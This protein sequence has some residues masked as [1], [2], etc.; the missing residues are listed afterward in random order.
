[1]HFIHKNISSP[2]PKSDKMRY[3]VNIINAFLIGIS[4]TKLDENILSSELEVNSYDLVRHD[5]S[6][7]VGDITCYITDLQQHRKYFCYHVFA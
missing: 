7:R 4:E 6:R 5:R 3:I 1:M 2:L